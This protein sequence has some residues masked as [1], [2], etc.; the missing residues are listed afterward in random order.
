LIVEPHLAKPINHFRKELNLAPI[1]RVLDQWWHKTDQVLC[2]FP[3]WFGPPQPDW[4]TNIV[5]SGFP[6][7]DGG[8]AE[9]FS[10]EVRAFLDA[11]EPPLVFTPGSANRD[12]KRFL[13]V[14]AESC[15]QLGKRGIL[16]TK[17]P[18]QLPPSLSDQ[19]RHFPFVPL[20][21]LLPLSA[22]FVNHAGIGS[23]SQGLAAGI[24]QLVQPMAFD[25]PDNADRLFRLGAARVLPPSR[26]TVKNVC[27]ALDALTKDHVVSE[28]CKV[29]AKCCHEAQALDRACD[30]LEDLAAAS[31]MKSIAPA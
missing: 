17:F 10:A 6:L 27:T 18:E 21:R 2:L 29:L 9:E 26:F 22:V 8:R 5:L 7:W 15:R 31:A 11:G 20:S 19:V 12:A 16:L 24:P 13:T 14:A 4:P 30:A 25:Q 1:N 3:D 28:R 23:C